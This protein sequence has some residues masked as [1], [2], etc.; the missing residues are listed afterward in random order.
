ML[1]V[2]M[3][4]LPQSCQ[5]QLDCDGFAAV[6]GLRRQRWPCRS[7]VTLEFEV[8]SGRVADE[9]RVITRSVLRP[10]PRLVQDLG[11]D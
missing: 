3:M 7:G 4:G 10:Q 6:L 5:G 9:H 2:V 11:A 8:V 1:M